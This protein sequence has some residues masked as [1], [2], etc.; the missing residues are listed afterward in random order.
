MQRAQLENKL[1]QA[2]QSRPKPE[3]LVNEGILKSKQPLL[4]TSIVAE[5]FEQRTKC[6]TKWMDGVI[7]NQ[8]T[9]PLSRSENEDI[10]KALRPSVY[11]SFSRLHRCSEK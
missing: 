2:L 6:L 8:C 10:P 9:I 3:E 5:P 1:G 4:L 7:G 11:V